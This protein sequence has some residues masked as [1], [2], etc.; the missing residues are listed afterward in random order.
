ML[1]FYAV[2]PFS[3]N[4]RILIFVRHTTTAS[5]DKATC[6]F[7][8]LVDGDWSWMPLTHVY[9]DQRI[10]LVVQA[11][12]SAGTQFFRGTVLTNGQASLNKS[13][14][15]F[16]GGNCPEGTRLWR[17]SSV[18]IVIFRVLFFGFYSMFNMED[19]VVRDQWTERCIFSAVSLLYIVF[20]YRGTD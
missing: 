10:A 8:A 1:E 6:S 19:G 17:L 11:L 14:V 5:R 16:T 4:Q 7:C 20:P 9:T 12:P 18:R 2:S 15:W 13:S 3:C